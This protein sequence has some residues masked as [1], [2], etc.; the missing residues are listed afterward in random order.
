MNAASHLARYLI[1]LLRAIGALAAVS[2]AAAGPP[3]IRNSTALTA[4]PLERSSGSAGPINRYAFDMAGFSAADK[5]ARVICRY[6]SGL[7]YACEHR[8]EGVAAD[9]VSR[10]VIVS[11]PDLD[12]GETVTLQF[13]NSAGSREIAL[14]IANP[15]QV[16]HEIETLVLPGGVAITGPDGRPAPITALTSLHA[17]TLPALTAAMPYRPDHCDQLYAQ[18]AGATVTDPV[19]SSAF[20]ALNGS[21]SVLQLPVPGSPVE[22]ENVP[23]WLVT[24]PRSAARVQFIAHYELRFRVGVCADRVLR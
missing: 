13:I 9:A 20:G 22:T 17:K 5:A 10:R 19:F 21:V 14:K 23:E 4:L 11:I 7:S 2:S 16:L 12:R 3:V 6:S 1:M 18:W 8:I 15:P 24:F